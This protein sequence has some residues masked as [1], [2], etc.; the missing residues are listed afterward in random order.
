MRTTNTRITLTAAALF[1][2]AASGCLDGGQ[3]P[4]VN[5][6]VEVRVYALTAEDVASMTVTVTGPGIEAPI[7]VTLTKVGDQW[8]ANLSEIPAGADRTF[9]LSARDAGGVEIYSG[10][11]TGVTI[12]AGQT[13]AVSI[14]GQENNPP[15]PV[16]NQAPVID[17]LTAST[18]EIAQGAS[19]ALSVAAHDND[20]GD[21]ITFLWTATGG[22]LA[23]PAQASTSWTAPAADGVYRVVVQVQDA[24]GATT[25][26]YVDLTVAE[27]ASSEATIAVTLNKWPVVSAVSSTQG[28]I[29][30]N[31]STQLDVVASD[32]D[33]DTLSYAWTVDSGCAGSFNQTSSKSPTFTLGATLP[34]SATCQFT[35]TVSD[36]HGG[37]NAG[38][39]TVSAA[40]APPVNLAPRITSA[41]QSVADAQA[42][43]A[44]NLSVQAE[45]P[46]AT[47]LT[48]TWT[49]T[50]GTL[51]TPSTTSDSSQVVWTAPDPFASDGSVSCT[52]A[53]ATGLTTVKTFTI[54]PIDSTAPT[55]AAFS[56][57]PTSVDVTGGPANVTVTA[58]ITDDLSGVAKAGFLVVDPVWV[59]FRICWIYRPEGEE[60]P[61]TL[62][63][64]CIIEIPQYSQ[65]GSWRVLE[66]YLH[67][68]AGNVRTMSRMEFEAMFPSVPGFAVT[69]SG[70]TDESAP[71]L[72]ALSLS[73]ATVDTTSG[74]AAVTVTFTATDDLSGAIETGVKLRSPSGAQS[75]SCRYYRAWETQPDPLTLTGSCVLDIPQ[76]SEPGV[77]TVE[78]FYMVDNVWNVF[79]PAPDVESRVGGFPATFTVV[80][81]S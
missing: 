17:A 2:L 80:A 49:T 29:D 71:E 64:S 76:D 34:T 23:T 59:Q 45:D 54:I 8:V 56:F 69:S 60:A 32:A 51:G 62:S 27:D 77:W 10:V 55:L 13:A 3:S 67:D 9:T 33:D 73:P 14:S 30:V 68:E 63:D 1:T 16:G 65:T 31:E 6:G 39:L 21:I 57:T 52:V 79:M 75:T 48:F 24:H 74:S 46:E 37:T 66:V 35:V 36:G 12:T 58:T 19:V 50:G 53:D 44:V 28:R 38:S 20:S 72:T 5:G 18:T 40:P 78:W 15:P 4:S 42:G 43:Q 61:Q 26:M 41:A 11:A 47:A 22:T 7:V 81:S 25:S 70:V